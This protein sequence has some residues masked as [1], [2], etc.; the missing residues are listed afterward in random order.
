[1]AQLYQ[2]INNFPQLQGKNA[3]EK[4]ADLFRRLGGAGQYTG[5]L[6]QNTWLLNN[7]NNGTAQRT[8][9]QTTVPAQAQ[10]Q[11][12]LDPYDALKQ[13]ALSNNL[14]KAEQSFEDINPFSNYFNEDLYRQ[15]VRQGL[16]P[17]IDRVTGNLKADDL[18]YRDREQQAFDNNIRALKQ[19]MANKGSF[20]GGA[21]MGQQRVQTANRNRDLDDYT[22]DYTNRMIENE[23]GFNR[24]IE[25]DTAREK[26]LKKTGWT[27]EKTNY[28]KNPNYK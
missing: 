10:T 17:E 7:I 26:Q 23:R 4:Q 6:Q 12:P 22:R 25:D 1:M 21:R 3:F 24:I 15:S 20:Y 18:S 28:Y 9:E 27:E 8:L 14:L 16:Q 13:T 11:A 5:S 2:I 19:G